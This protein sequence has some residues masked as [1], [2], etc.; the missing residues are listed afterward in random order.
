L[1]RYSRIK[2]INHKKYY[3]V[4]QPLGYETDLSPQTKK[5]TNVGLLLK[6]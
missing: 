6:S 5:P 3:Q 4:I 2:L 1:D